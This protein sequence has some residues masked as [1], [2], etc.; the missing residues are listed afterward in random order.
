MM[1]QIVFSS[2]VTLEFSREYPASVDAVW[3]ALTDAGE[4]SDWMGYECTFDPRP[5]GL[6]TIGVAPRID[7]AVVC[8]IIPCKVLVTMFRETLI[9]QTLESRH[10]FTSHRIRQIGV[11]PES[12]AS[13]A[14]GWH[15]LLDRLTEHITGDPH[16]VMLDRIEAI[17]EEQFR[18]YAQTHGMMRPS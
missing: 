5:G 18:A 1:Q 8:Q 17:Y 16:D 13:F 12:A 2:A 15:H 10:G 4:I 9:F 7:H 6:F 3:R 14:C 11:L